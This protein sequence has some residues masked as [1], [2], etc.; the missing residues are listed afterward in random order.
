MDQKMDEGSGGHE[1]EWCV[2]KTTPSVF[3]GLEEERSW[4]EA[5]IY[6]D[7]L[8]VAEFSLKTHPAF[9]GLKP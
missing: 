3:T 1:R 8:Q 6:C 7:S 4:G 5:K 9:K 2:T